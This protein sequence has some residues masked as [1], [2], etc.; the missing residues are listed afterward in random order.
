MILLIAMTFINQVKLEC[1]LDGKKCYNFKV[2][3]NNEED[4]KIESEI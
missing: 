4:K 3:G 1:C 2:D